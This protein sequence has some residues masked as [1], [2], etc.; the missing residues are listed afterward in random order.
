MTNEFFPPTE[1]G[2]EEMIFILKKKLENEKYSDEWD[3][4]AEELET[5]EEQLQQLILLNNIL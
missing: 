3:E 5:K 1:T 4:L 2:L